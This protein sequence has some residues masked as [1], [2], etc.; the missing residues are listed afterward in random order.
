[1]IRFTLRQAS[2]WSVFENVTKSAHFVNTLIMKLF[3]FDPM[4]FI[5]FYFGGSNIYS[6]VIICCASC[7]VGDPLSVLCL[8]LET[9]I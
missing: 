1:M 7:Q 8:L 9:L 5:V 4:H 2:T 3:I 6:T